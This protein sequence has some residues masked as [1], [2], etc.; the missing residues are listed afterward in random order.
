M[1][2]SD[3]VLTRGESLRGF[4]L[5]KGKE[6]PE[7]CINPRKDIK[8]SIFR[9]NGKGKASPIAPHSTGG[10]RTGRNGRAREL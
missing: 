10:R 1:K 4:V 3:T 7:G 8:G 2:D 9:G 6:Y 5:G